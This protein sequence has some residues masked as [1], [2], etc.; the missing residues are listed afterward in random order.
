MNTS[1]P[2][3][4]KIN[5]PAKKT[6]MEMMMDA[7]MKAA[8]LDPA[9]INRQIAQVGDIVAMF[10]AQLDRIEAQNAE[11]IEICKVGNARIDMLLAKMEAN[12]NG[13]QVEIPGR[14]GT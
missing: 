13:Q 5:A 9:A 11:I 10:K 12:S 3:A 8:G 4:A 7:A 14:S 2:F 1:F 6:G